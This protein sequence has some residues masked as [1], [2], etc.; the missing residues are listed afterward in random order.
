MRQLT[1]EE[2]HTADQLIRAR[3]ARNNYGMLYNTDPAISLRDH[4]AFSEAG[5]DIEYD[6]GF[7]YKD[8]AP[9]YKIK[10]QYGRGG[11]EWLPKLEYIG[12]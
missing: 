7:I 5:W 4:M 10:K 2:K 1:K 8:G 6:Q 3:V 11:R 12:A 9:A